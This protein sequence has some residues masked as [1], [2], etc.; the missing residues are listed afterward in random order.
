MSLYG[1][2]KTSFADKD[3]YHLSKNIADQPINPTSKTYGV[4]DAS[5]LNENAIISESNGE[6][7]LLIEWTASKL[8]PCFSLTVSP[9]IISLYVDHIADGAGSSSL[10]TIRR[11]EPARWYVFSPDL[12]TLR[13]NLSFGPKTK[14]FEFGMF[15]T[16]DSR[17][18]K[19]TGFLFGSTN[20]GIYYEIETRTI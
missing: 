13:P 1:N 17:K 11:V 2:L 18:F 5:K 15:F 6:Q 3:H 7:L 8:Q 9:G 19:V 10:A 20:S 14:K 4:I 12:V 16:N